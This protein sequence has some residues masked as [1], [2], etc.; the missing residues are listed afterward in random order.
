MIIY[1]KEFEHDLQKVSCL[2]SIYTIV[3]FFASH[4][5]IANPLVS[6]AITASISSLATLAVYVKKA[7][8]LA[9]T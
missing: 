8:S 1:L 7:S 4:A 9:V 5:S 3:F 2:R 6:S